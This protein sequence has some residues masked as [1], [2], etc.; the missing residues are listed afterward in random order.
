MIDPTRKKSHYYD[1]ADAERE[2]VQ[3]LTRDRDK[4]EAEARY[5]REAYFEHMQEH[6][7][8]VVERALRRMAEERS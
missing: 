6:H 8:D 2:R 3:Q 4:A 7:P 1:T 5:W